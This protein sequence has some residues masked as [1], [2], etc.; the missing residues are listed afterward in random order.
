MKRVRL[1][2]AVDFSVTDY[3]SASDLII[4]KA[5]AR[6]SFGVFAMPVHG[7]VLAA[8]NHSMRSAASRAQLIV[9]DGQP[10]RWALNML[11]KTNLRDRVYGPTLTLHV[12]EKA[13]HKRLNVFLYGGNS[14]DTLERFR[15][16]ILLNYPGVCICG[17][18]REECPDQSTLDADEVNRLQTHILLVGRG[19]PAQ[20]IWISDQLGRVKAVMMGV[21]AAFSFHAG[22]VQQAPG[23][24]Q[25]MGLEWLFRLVREPKRLFR[26]YAYTNTLFLFFLAR[27]Y[28]RKFTRRSWNKV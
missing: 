5:E 11:H 27:Q 12:L 2:D 14:K 7:L 20:E 8:T 15:D 23:W 10:V 21:G 26:R 28:M 13:S 6:E 3:Q 9:P 22:T 25:R 1:F 18:Y 17:A 24:M 19:C 16:F 4:S